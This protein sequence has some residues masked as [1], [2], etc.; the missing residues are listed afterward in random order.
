MQIKGIS[1]C[2]VSE[3]KNASIRMKTEPA[4]SEVNSNDLETQRSTL[5]K[6]MCKKIEEI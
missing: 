1:P 4:H 2:G 5:L 6:E 3:K